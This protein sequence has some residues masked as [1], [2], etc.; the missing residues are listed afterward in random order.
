VRHSQI[1]VENRR[2]NHLYFGAP[3]GG[4]P[5]GISPRSLATKLQRL[6]FHLV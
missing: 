6:P 5:V 4:D 2:F 3:V 1:L